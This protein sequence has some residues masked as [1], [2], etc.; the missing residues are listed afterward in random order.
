MSYDPK[1]YD[2]AE[3][4]LQDHPG[5]PKEAADD[6]AQAIQDAIEEWFEDRLIP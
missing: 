6:L 3:S 2:L 4:F 5:Y 1:C